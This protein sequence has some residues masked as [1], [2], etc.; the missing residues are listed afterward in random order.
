RHTRCSRDWSSDVC[1]SDLA[2]KKEQQIVLLK[3]ET[4]LYGLQLDKQK[5]QDI[6]Q[7]QE[8]SMLHQQNEISRLQISEK[9]LAFENQQKETARSQK[10]RE[11][12]AAIAAKENQQK[13]F[14][15]LAIAIILLCGC[16]VVFRSMQNKR[17]SK[18]L[19]SSLTEL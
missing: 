6:Q 18:Q 12:Q 4:E 10:E 1:S 13:K 9:T 5:I 19:A 8:L 3:N 11:L 7:S 14:A 16:F 2:E 17:L 15:Y